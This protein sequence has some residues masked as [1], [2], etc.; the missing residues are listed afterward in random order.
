MFSQ[1][2]P[3]VKCGNCKSFIAD[4]LHARVVVSRDGIAEAY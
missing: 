2:V 1:C 4:Y 3:I